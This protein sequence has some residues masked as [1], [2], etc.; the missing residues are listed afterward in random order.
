M[1][2]CRGKRFVIV[3]DLIDTT[4]CVDAIGTDLILMV[5]ERVLLLELLQLAQKLGARQACLE[6]LRQSTISILHHPW[7]IARWLG[8]T[9][10][11]TLEVTGSLQ[12]QPTEPTRRLLHSSVGC[13]ASESSTSNVPRA[14]HRCTPTGLESP[15]VIGRHLA[16]RG[17]V[18]GA[19]L[20]AIYSRQASSRHE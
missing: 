14:R 10:Q 15:T 9:R 13:S 17:T 5:I 20:L 12:L 2:C 16:P 18:N 19:L 4:V 8:R 1:C 6:P 7:Q 3:A 11:H